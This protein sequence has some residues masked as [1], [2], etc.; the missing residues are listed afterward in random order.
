MKFFKVNVRE[1]DISKLLEDFAFTLHVY[2]G[3]K[4][5]TKNAEHFRTAERTKIRNNA[6]SYAEHG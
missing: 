1:L 2:H 5:V 3:R 6:H 4:E